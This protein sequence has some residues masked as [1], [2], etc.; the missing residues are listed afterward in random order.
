M[1]KRILFCLALLI[2]INKQV[3][4]Q[5]ENEQTFEINFNGYVH[6]TA[7]YDSRQTVAAREGH[8]FLYPKN[9]ELD[10]NGTDV[11]AA[12]N[13][14][15][16]VIQTRAGVSIKGPSFL[17]A[18]TNGLIEAE[19]LGNSDNDVNGMRLRHSYINFDWQNTSLLIGQT[20]IPLFVVEVFPQ[21]IGSSTG[22]P[23]QPFGRNP[24][25]RLTQKFDKFKTIFALLS[26]R[27]YL[28]S[29]PNQSS[30][31][32]LRNAITPD[33]HIQLQYNEKNMVLGIGGE[34]KNLRP[35]LKTELGYTTKKKVN[36]YAAI[37]FCK[38]T[39]SP[40]TLRLYGLY[41]ANLTDYT[42]LGGYAATNVDS[43]TMIR[44]YTPTKTYSVWT[45]V[46][47]GDK[48]EYGIFA[49]YT[50]NLGADKEVITPFYG[51]G[52]D[53]DHIYRIAPRIQYT[54]GK[55]KT[56]FEVEFTSAA[57]GKNDS[58]GKVIDAQKVLNTRAYVAAF[59]FF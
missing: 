33:A 24:Q 37:S 4:S 6:W 54:E 45:D 30:V 11:N 18:K 44:D 28:S 10:A 23:I 59:Y 47:Y 2:S 27:D 58:K 25:I 19:F 52:M 20:W 17:G 7:I 16:L 41:G 53:I 31:E 49:G 12:A 29:G 46:S 50:K 9:K 36:G 21:Q 40:V 35:A 5:Q 39:F 8:F 32:Y 15:M 22:A 43:S 57:Y 48:L 34:Y 1:S 14:N 13:F 26:H 55:V 56:S 38:F 51:R 3:F 42:M